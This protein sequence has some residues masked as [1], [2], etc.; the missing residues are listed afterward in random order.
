MAPRIPYGSPRHHKEWGDLPLHALE[1]CV[2]DIRAERPLWK[3]QFRPPK[4]ALSGPQPHTEVLSWTM[5][6]PVDFYRLQVPVA[7]ALGP[8]VWAK[9]P[10]RF[11][12]IR[13]FGTASPQVGNNLHPHSPGPQRDTEAA[14]RGKSS[15]TFREHGW[16]SRKP[17][18]FS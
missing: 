10:G 14:Y 17:I 2:E 13:F 1:L 15:I 16:D 8:D 9:I 4:I 11:A 5:R 3:T 12:Q 18:C 7:S 6:S